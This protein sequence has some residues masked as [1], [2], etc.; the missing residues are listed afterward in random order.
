[1]DSFKTII[2]RIYI[3]LPIQKTMKL[4]LGR[5]K[6]LSDDSPDRRNKIIFLKKNNIMK[7]TTGT[8]KS[9]I[10]SAIQ[11]TWTLWWVWN[12]MMSKV[13]YYFDPL[14]AMIGRAKWVIATYSVSH[15]CKYFTFQIFFTKLKKNNKNSTHFCKSPFIINR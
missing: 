15:Q 4:K 9:N 2:F 7:L 10:Y 8:I 1:M 3:N 5:S 6:W 11:K 14:F 12:C 13:K